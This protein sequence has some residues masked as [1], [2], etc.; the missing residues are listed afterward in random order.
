M[1]ASPQLIMQ[2][3]NA[4]CATSALKA[5][6]E[7]GVF[8]ALAEGRATSEEIAERCQSSRRGIRILCDFL[9]IAGL[10]EKGDG[11]YRNTPDTAY[12]LDRKSPAYIG[13]A[14][15]FLTSHWL[16]DA[17]RNVTTVVRTG[18]TQLSEE[19]T[20]EADHPVWVTFAKSMAPIMSPAAGEMAAMVEAPV[21]KVLDVAAGHGVFGIAFAKA[22]PEAEVVAIDWIHVLEVA[23]EHAAQAGV[24]ERYRTIEGSVF[25]LDVGAG[26]DVALLTNFY[27]HFNRDTCTRLATKIRQTLAPGGCMITLEFIPNEDR[28][29]PPPLASFALTMLATTAEGDAYTFEDY[30]T[31]F[32]NAG[33]RRNEMR[34]LERS[35]QRVIVSR[36]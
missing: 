20:M 2:T 31:M 3:F 11:Q 33:F 36:Q 30:R 22:H 29:T 9:A 15:E 7:L 21:R 14:A 24:I 28:V 6:I 18:H 26:Y 16:F 1:P 34:Q 35:P 13:D 8:S 25:D 19:G 5:A 12:Y 23:R 27:H 32:E 4:H 17:F 10:L